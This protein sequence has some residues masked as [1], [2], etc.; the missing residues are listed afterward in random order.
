MCYSNGGIDVVAHAHGKVILLGEHA[1][2]YGVPAIAAGIERGASARAAPGEPVWLE[3]DARRVQPDDGS[4]LGQAFG[5]LLR[6]LGD[7]AVQIR[8]ELELPPGAG[9]GASAALGV[10][11][12][13]AVVALSPHPDEA[14]VAAAARA[15][16]QVFHGNPSGVDAAAA[17]LGG[18]IW[19]ERE[20]GPKPLKLARDLELA[21]G[22]AAPPA[23]TRAMVEQVAKLRERRPSVV[24]KALAG[25]R[26]LVENARGCLEAG[27]LPGLGK[28]LDLNQMILSGLFLSTDRIE[29]ACRLARDHGALGAKLTGSGGG[30]AVI[31]LVEQAEPVLAAW[32]EVGIDAFSSRIRA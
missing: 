6:A 29:T 26:S 9:L 5:G 17:A 21:I 23:S 22:L 11:L 3:L 30:G 19:F 32:R 15:W 12:A 2:V 1:V 8:A 25:I 27:D 28:L 24:D 13:R 10:A 16:E 4:E 14:R 7:P 31:A 18:C 20:L